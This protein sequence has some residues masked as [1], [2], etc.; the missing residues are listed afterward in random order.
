MGNWKITFNIIKKEEHSVDIE[1]EDYKEAVKKLSGLVDQYLNQTSN[2][3]QIKTEI[4]DINGIPFS[5]IGSK[6]E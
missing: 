1:A 4:K 2:L 3:I 5:F 6:N